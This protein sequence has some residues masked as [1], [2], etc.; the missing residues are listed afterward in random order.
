MSEE[1]KVYVSIAIISL[2]LIL[3]VA[4]YLNCVKE[5]FKRNIG[6]YGIILLLLSE[7]TRKLL[8]QHSYVPF[9]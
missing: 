9:S 2:F 3:T 4:L 6:V 1:S 7:N 5:C 8:A